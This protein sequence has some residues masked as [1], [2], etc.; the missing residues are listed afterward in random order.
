MGGNALLAEAYALKYG[1]Q[2]VWEKGYKRVIWNVD[3][4]GLLQALKDEESRIFL[5]IPEDIN[6]LMGHQWSVA[7]R[8]IGRD[9][10]TPADWLAKRGASSPSV[11]W[12]LLDDPPWELEILILRDQ[13]ASL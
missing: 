4:K 8:S 1:L 11:A 10:N 6:E 5:P 3:C 12:C 13:L 2:L 9:C 7:V